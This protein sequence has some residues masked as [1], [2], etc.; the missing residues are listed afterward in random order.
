MLRSEVA[1]HNHWSYTAVGK[2]TSPWRAAVLTLSPGWY[3]RNFAGN[4]AVAMADGVSV[5][6]WKTAWAAYRSKDAFGPF[7]DMPWVTDNTLAS[8]AGALHQASVI[9][10]AG[11]DSGLP[12][13]AGLSEAMSE[14][15]R[16]KGATGYAMARMQRV[17]AVVDEFARAAV[18]SKNRRLNMPQEMAWKRATEAMVDYHNLSP[19][20]R[21]AV[22]SVI[23]F[24]SWQKGILK[25]TANQALDHPARAAILQ[26]LGQMQE[27]Y[28]AGVFGVDGGDVPEYYRHIILGDKNIRSWNPF[29]DTSDILSP[30]G[31]A[32]SMN[33]FMEIAV[34]KG[35]GAPDFFPESFRMG[36]F[37]TVEEDVNVPDELGNLATS[38]PAGQIL[39]FGGG[40]GKVAQMGLHDQDIAKL[41]ERIKKSRD[42][43]AT[44]G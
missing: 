1:D 25:V 6:D 20:E 27:D 3:A 30:E 19:F 22:R 24:Y 2:I 14:S 38:S 9:P 29:A 13:R 8:E 5:A 40:P 43:I 15:G 44:G 23:P 7:K 4:L 18:Y 36:P 17:N 10:R 34:R 35:L 28:V 11:G 26:Q 32:K 39:G 42:R 12:S 31:I 41:S 21:S 16:I 33:P 37:G